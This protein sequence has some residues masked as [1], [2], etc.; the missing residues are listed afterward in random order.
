MTTH[1]RVRQHD[2][3]QPLDEPANGEVMDGASEPGREPVS[4]TGNKAETPTAPAPMKKLGVV[5]DGASNDVDVPPS[6]FGTS[7]AP[8][9]HATYEE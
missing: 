6:L 3:D 9:K 5:M 7:F 2:E 8:K 4:I 1:K